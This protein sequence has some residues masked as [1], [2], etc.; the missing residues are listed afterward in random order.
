MNSW[1][2]WAAAAIFYLYEFVLRVAPGVIVNDL[3]SAFSVTAPSLGILT[4]FYYYAYTPMQVPCGVI[5]DKFGPR[6]VVTFST[7]LCIIGTMLF[8][9]TEKIFIA[10]IGRFLIGMGSACAFISC[11]KV[12]SYW[13]PKRKMAKLAGL[14]NMMGILGGTFAAYPFAILSNNYGWRKALIICAILGIFV[15]FFVSALSKRRY[16][17]PKI[18]KS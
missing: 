16:S 2:I 10:G 7:I 18:S 11:L 13:F 3:M 6:L 17:L 8:A 15:A 12:S 1:L 14:T 9:T 4:S 5:V